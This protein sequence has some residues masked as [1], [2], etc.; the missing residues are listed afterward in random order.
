MLTELATML[1]DYAL[2]M[3]SAFLGW[4]LWMGAQAE[5]GMSVRYWAIGMGS[6]A[7]ASFAGGTVHGWALM[8]SQPVLSALWK[9]TALMIGL[10]SFC[11]F[12]GTLT[13]SVA[14]PLRRLLML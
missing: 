9:A 10:A 1:T 14:L 4:R 11:F 6:L 8:L 12:V 5:K 13:A 7:V 3:L 2:G